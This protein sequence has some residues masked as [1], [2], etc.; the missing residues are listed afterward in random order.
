MVE[1]RLVAAG[2]EPSLQTAGSVARLGS[3]DACVELEE[4]VTQ[5]VGPVASVD[6]CTSVVAVFHN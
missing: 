6:S 4:L 3:V 5:A 1:F 2:L